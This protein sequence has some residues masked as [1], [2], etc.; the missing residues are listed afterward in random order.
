MN[1]HDFPQEDFEH[2][3]KYV[4][5]NLDPTELEQ[6]EQRL[7][8][9]AEFRS[10]VEELK[11]T[12]IGIEAQ[13]LK[14]QLDIFHEEL[15]ENTC[16]SET[17]STKTTTLNWKYILVAAALIIAAGSF[18]FLKTDTNEQLYAKYFSPD[19]GLPTAMSSSDN[20]EFYEA[21][22]SYKQGHYQSAIS[23]WE[24][25]QKKKPNNDTLN[26]FIGVAYLADKNE[27]TAIPFLEEVVKDSNFPLIDDAFYYLGLA[28]LKTQNINKAKA[29]L[30]KS[31]I[32]N[33]KALLS[34]LKN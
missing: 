1:V 34:E 28:Y 8:N 11:V 4:N 33:S 14:E 25:L 20:Y 6:F 7:L 10:K 16:T 13:A 29:N 30:H 22:V 27:Q 12:L 26:Y 32:D 3:E 17:E 5:G 21:M 18:W 23:K 31:T 9:D 2:I 15:H 24:I 19:P